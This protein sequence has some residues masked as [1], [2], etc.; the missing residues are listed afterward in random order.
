MAFIID[1][2]E[3]KLEALKA[4]AASAGVSLEEW[5]TFLAAEQQGAALSVLPDYAMSRESTYTDP[6]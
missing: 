5:L 4:R 6:E 1:L 2:P 3:D